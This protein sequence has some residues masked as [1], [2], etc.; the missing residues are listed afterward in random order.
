MLGLNLRDTMFCKP[1]QILAYGE[2]ICVILQTHFAIR[3]TLIIFEMLLKI[4]F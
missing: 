1:V 3:E 2:H 4:N